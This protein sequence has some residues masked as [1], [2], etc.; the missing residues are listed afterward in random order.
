MNFKL[1]K[2]KNKQATIEDIDY[3]VKRKIDKSIIKISLLLEKQELE[4]HIFH[5]L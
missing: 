2:I 3:S 1:S 5:K 4:N